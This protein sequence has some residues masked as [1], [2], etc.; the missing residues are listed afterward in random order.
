M[1]KTNWHHRKNLDTLTYLSANIVLGEPIHPRVPDMVSFHL[2]IRS[3]LLLQ[4]GGSVKNDWQTMQIQ[5]RRLVT[6]VS[7]LFAKVSVLVCRNKMVNDTI[8]K[9]DSD[10]AGHPLSLSN[11]V[12][13]AQWVAEDQRFLHADSEESDQTA[14]MPRLIWVFAGLTC[15]FVGFVMRWFKM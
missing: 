11:P 10:Q 1:P 14:W 4:I 5:V 6:S 8:M 7:T 12:L 13:C 2:Q 9:S 3:Y 15:H